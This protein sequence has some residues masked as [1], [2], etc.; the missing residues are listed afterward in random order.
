MAEKTAFSERLGALLRNM[1]DSDGAPQKERAEHSNSQ[2][3]A[4]PAH[5]SR[6]DSD[7]SAKPLNAS[8]AHT[9]DDAVH[10]FNRL[11]AGGLRRGEI[12]REYRYT[13]PVPQNVATAYALIGIAPRAPLAVVQKSF[14]K[15]IK[16]M[17]PDSGGTAD[18][19]QQLI[20]AY[21]VIV[22]W[23]AEQAASAP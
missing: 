2:S 6:A 13:P 22:R 11:T 19:A 8:R 20:A 14:R 18:K 17:H 5:E 7:S 3:G 23:L 21:E 10:A 1:L 4:Q 12:V 9:P 16:R 15:K